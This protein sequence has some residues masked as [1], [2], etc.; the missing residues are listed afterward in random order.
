MLA[1]QF[2]WLD[3]FGRIKRQTL[4]TTAATIALALTEVATFI[5]LFTPTS[6][7]GLVQVSISTKD[8][9]D[10]YAA[11]AGSNVDVNA[12][13]Q[14]VGADG[15]NY[16]LNIPMIKDAFVTGGGAIVISDAVIVAHT[17]QFLVAGDWR[18]NNRFPTAIT[19]VSSGQL[20][21]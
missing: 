11:V 12:S 15:F 1:V 14:V 6:D 3:G 10:A 16:D 9:T 17:D 2:A 7:A 8:N 4:T 5:A 21:K 20:D 18:V 19:S 13:L